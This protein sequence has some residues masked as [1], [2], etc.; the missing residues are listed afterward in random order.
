MRWTGLACLHARDLAGSQ[1]ASRKKD[2]ANDPA[3][4]L[5]QGGWTMV[6]LVHEWRGNSRRTGQERRARRR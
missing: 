5:L 1:P 2:E 6:L 4:E 3:L